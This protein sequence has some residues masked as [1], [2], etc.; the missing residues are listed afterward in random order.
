M[1]PGAGAMSV[2]GFLSYHSTEYIIPPPTTIGPFSS[3][4]REEFVLSMR[5]QVERLLALQRPNW[6]SYG[7][8]PIATEAVERAA[9]LV[10]K[11]IDHELPVPRLYPLSDGGVRLEWV[12]PEAE[13]HIDLPVV[14]EPTAYYADERTGDEWEGS[15]SDVPEALLRLVARSPKA[16]PRIS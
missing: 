5:R 9:R 16:A 10:L 14:D 6:D 8:L 3:Y 11:L 4:D 7:A 15:I 13:V 12:G 2:E 1:T